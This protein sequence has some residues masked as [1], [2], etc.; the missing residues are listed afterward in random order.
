MFERQRMAQRDQVT[1]ALGCLD[2]RQSGGCQDSSLGV[3]L[4][5]NL[6]PG[7]RAHADAG[8]GP[9]DPPGGVLLS[10]IDHPGLSGGVQVRELLAFHGVILASQG[11]VVKW[12]A[13]AAAG[14]L[15]RVLD[16]LRRET[17]IFSREMG[18]SMLLRRF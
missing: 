7:F 15:S 8:P 13:A 9:G 17:T 4:A 10:Y 16:P 3:G 11:P 14:R 12:Q 18:L 2:A 6:F 1:G 5:G